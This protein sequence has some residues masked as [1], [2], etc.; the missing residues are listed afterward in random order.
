MLAIQNWLIQNNFNYPLLEEQ[1]SI[2]ANFASNDER[3]I[4][5]Y[6]QIN[7]PKTNEIVK[8]CRGTVLHK[9]NASLVGRGFLRFFNV[10]EDKDSLDK[11]NWNNCYINEKVDGSYICVYK[12]E[13]K[14]RVN[15]RNSYADGI[16]NDSG[17]TWLD[18][19]NQ[20]LPEGFTLQDFDLIA[21]EKSSIIFELCSP[22]NQ[23]VKFHESPKLFLLAVFDDGIE[24]NPVDVDEFAKLNR[25]TRPTRVHCSSILDVEEYIKKESEKDRAFEGLV[26]NDNQNIRLKLKSEDYVK[27]HRTITGNYT[28]NKNLIEYVIDNE[29]DEILCYCPYLKDKI[30][31]IEQLLH[32]VKTD[33]DNNFRKFHNIVSRKTFAEKVKDIPLN[34]ILFSN[35]GTKYQDFSINQV[36]L[37]NKDKIIVHINSIIC[38]SV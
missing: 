24:R 25:F 3:V 26:L 34:Y 20:A 28:S 7:S 5:N 19:F 11:F 14:W 9:T 17:L 6:C 10:G 23:V 37:D 16:V 15:T 33:L 22:F 30:L 29:Q 32:N 36:I 8:S 21:D 4:L 31:R 13:G 27:L 1:L 35:Y 38:K 18:I 2:K 12:F